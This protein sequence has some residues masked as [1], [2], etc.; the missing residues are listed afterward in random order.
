M[1]IAFF[2]PLNPVRSGIADY[3]EELL[4]Y[5]ADLAEVDI[6]ID[7]YRPASEEITRRF[8]ILNA[9]GFLK[10]RDSYDCAIYQVGNNFQSAGYMLP[11]MQAAPGI[12]VI[13]DYSLTYLMLPLTAQR[14][15][16][17]SLEAMLGPTHGER[18]RAA[19]WRMTLGGLDPYQ[20]SLARPIVEMSRAV[21]VHNRHAFRKLKAEFP[22][23]RLEHIPHAT[24]IHEPRRDLDSLRAAYGFAAGDFIL[25]SVSSVAYNKRLPIVLG[26]LRDLRREH[27]GLKFVMVGQGDLGGAGRALI[28]RYGL[29]QNVVQTG[30]VSSQQYLDYIDLADVVV[31]LRYPTAGETS[32]SSLRALQAGKPLVVS[33]E[34]FFLELPDACCVRLPVDGR[35]REA[36]RRALA[37]LIG[38]EQKRRTM[39]AAGREFAV[40]HLRR[41]QAAQSYFELAREVAAARYAPARAW[42]F[43]EQPDRSPRGR[44]V[45]AAYKA[46][47]VAYYYRRYGLGGTWKRIRSEVGGGG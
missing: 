12:A 23:V 8:P 34:G 27:P 35:E 31:D 38:D 39:G 32:G 45:S 18:S 20:V 25:A 10:N 46:G 29:E 17:D 36:L 4:P 2:T 5:L 16:L 47:R 9:A 28:R 6:V 21:I 44:L 41:E 24:P 14:G 3:S 22:G 1:R 40:T 43:R 19:A 15:D 26:A 33:A 7:D 13:H 30:W 11:C 42:N 37:D